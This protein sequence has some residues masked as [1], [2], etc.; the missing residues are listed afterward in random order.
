MNANGP[1]GLVMVR[2]K[3]AGHSVKDGRRRAGCFS[4]WAGVGSP[5]FPPTPARSRQTPPAIAGRSVVD[6]RPRPLL[7]GETKGLPIGLGIVPPKTLA[8][9]EFVAQPMPPRP[10]CRGLRRFRS[11]GRTGSSSLQKAIRDAAWN[12]GY[13]SIITNRKQRYFFTTDQRRMPLIVPVC[14]GTG[15]EAGPTAQIHNFG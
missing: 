5:P 1:V 10:D 14:E 9:I 2:A 7:I 6:N 8:A 15:K 4:S 12:A 13:H 3:A 11:P